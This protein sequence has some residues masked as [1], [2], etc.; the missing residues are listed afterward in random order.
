MIN[1]LGFTLE[2]FDA[3]GRYRKDE[4]GKPVDATGGYRTRNGEILNFSG[5]RDLA[6][7]LANSE[8]THSAFVEQLF[9]GLIKQPI[10]AF[11]SQTRSVLRQK[12]VENNFNIRKLVIEIVATAALP[13][14]E[15]TP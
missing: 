13:R 10:R 2:H 11:G 9:H 7:F 3:V 1:P 4:N 12:F 14:S 15:Q 8:E 5:V 6:T